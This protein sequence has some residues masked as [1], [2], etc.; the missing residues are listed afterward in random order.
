M[1]TLDAAQVKTKIQRKINEAVSVMTDTK[2]RSVIIN[3]N[4]KA[5]VLHV[6]MYDLGLTTYQDLESRVLKQ[7]QDYNAALQQEGLI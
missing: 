5:Q 3:N 6:L 1:A 4:A 7:S 2:Q